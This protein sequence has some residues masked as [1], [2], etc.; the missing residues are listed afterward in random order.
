MSRIDDLL[1]QLNNESKYN[2]LNE[3]F[4]FDSIYKRFLSLREQ[5]LA[6]NGLTNT[7]PWP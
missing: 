6:S 3:S 2:P 5:L 7:L 4:D 1:I